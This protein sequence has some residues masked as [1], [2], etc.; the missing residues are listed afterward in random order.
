MHGLAHFQLQVT[1]D[2]TQEKQVYWPIKLK[3]G[4]IYIRLQVKFD[5]GFCCVSLT[6]LMLISACLQAGLPMF[7]GFYNETNNVFYYT[8]F[9]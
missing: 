8:A 7:P 6:L 1:K 9:F 4:Q 5:Q 2:P 3:Y